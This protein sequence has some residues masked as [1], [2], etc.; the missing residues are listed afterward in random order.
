MLLQSH[1]GYIEPLAA[2]PD[3]W[4]SGEYRGLCARGGFEVSV[5]WR[6]GRAEKIEIVSKQGGI[7]RVKTELSVLTCGGNEV[8]CIKEGET[9]SFE[10]EK[11]GVYSFEN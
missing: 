10:T 5:K 4:E 3:L 6:K 1:E 9:V 11:G 2:V 7:C 8:S